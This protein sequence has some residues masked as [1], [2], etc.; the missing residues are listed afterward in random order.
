MKKKIKLVKIRLSSRLWGHS[1][2]CS[3]AVSRLINTQQ[4]MNGD[5][6]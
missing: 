1:T 4:Q 5:S 2:D 3:G 6:V